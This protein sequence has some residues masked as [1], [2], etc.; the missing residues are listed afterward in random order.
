MPTVTLV[1]NFLPYVL[2]HISSCTFFTNPSRPRVH[3]GLH[4]TGKSTPL[5]LFRSETYSLSFSLSLSFRLCVYTH[6]L[7]LSLGYSSS[8]C[9]SFPFY[10]PLLS[11]FPSPSLPVLLSLFVS[12][13][14]SVSRWTVGVSTP[15]E[16]VQT[17]SFTVGETG[18][19]V[20]FSLVAE[21]K[22]S[23]HHLTRL[24]THD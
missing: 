2:L 7:S 22:D 3:E 24:A 23:L 13:L 15:T 10:L 1:H 8:V 12:S 4:R 14:L 6:H 20:C 9:H 11:F 16:V 19:F 18:V 17:E 5:S 21:E